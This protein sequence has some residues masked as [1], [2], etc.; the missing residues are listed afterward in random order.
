MRKIT[1]IISTSLIFVFCSVS[2]A[3]AHPGRLDSKGGH[4]VRKPGLG[5]PVGS[6]HYH[7]GGSG[8]S[9]S[10]GTSS[11]NKINSYNAKDNQLYEKAFT[12]VSNCKNSD[13]QQS[14]NNARDA[15]SSL[16]G[17]GASWAIGE[18]SKQVDGVQQKLF[19]EFMGILFEKNGFPIKEVS[20]EK[21]NRA[22]ELVNEFATYNGNKP[23]VSSWSSAVDKVQKYR[24]DQTRV[25]LDEAKK[26]KNEA[27]INQAKT[28]II[29]L[30][31]VKN[32]DLVYNYAKT[33]EAEVNLIKIEDFAILDAYKEGNTLTVKFNKDISDVASPSS[34]QFTILLEG[35]E[36]YIAL[37]STKEATFEIKDGN[38]VYATFTNTESFD[39][40]TGIHTNFKRANFISGKW[41][42]EVKELNYKFK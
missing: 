12:E 7:N 31:T 35:Q 17:S 36:K 23:Y 25:F 39:K 10:T 6:Y 21:I 5:Y 32:N 18:F 14:I 42:D 24:M 29:E 26:F 8:S 13:T 3:Y 40:A 1:R 30:L 11:S 22:R 33:L 2:I 41:I 4:Y 34:I 37:G 16:K 19:E 15:V 20:Q 9:T 27:T 38:I 28:H